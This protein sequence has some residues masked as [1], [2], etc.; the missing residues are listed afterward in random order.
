[1]GKIKNLLKDELNLTLRAESLYSDTL[2]SVLSYDYKNKSDSFLKDFSIVLRQRAMSG[3]PLNSLLPEAFALA[4]EASFRVLKLRPH[5]TQILA[6]IVLHN[7]QIAQMQTGEGKTLAAVLPAYLNGLE[8]KGVHILTFNDYLAKRD[9]EWMGPVFKFLGLSVG[10]ISGGMV[11]AERKMAYD[12]SVTYSSAKEVGFDYL[13]DFLCLKAELLVQRPFNFTI[14]DEADSIMIDEARIP[15]I[16]SG[17][18]TETEEYALKANKIVNNFKPGVHYEADQYDNNYYFTDEGINEAEK[19]LKIGNIYDEA[20]LP[21]LVALNGALTAYTLLQRDRNYLVRNNSIE[22]IDEFT[23]RV[24][25]QRLYPDNIQ[26]AVEI[27]EGIESNSRGSIM[28]RIALQHFLSLYQKLA[29]MTGTA[30]SAGYEFKSLYKM[31]V[32]EV[33]PYKPCQR[34]DQPDRVFMTKSQ[35]EKAIIEEVVSLNSKGQ[36]ILIGTVDIEES[37]QLSSM[38]KERGIRCSVLNAKNDEQEA[39]IIAEAGMPYAVTVSTNMAGRGVDIRLGGSDEREKDPVMAL[40]GLYVLGTN[41]HESVRID[42]QL[43]GRSG[44]QGEPGESRFFISLEDE[45]IKKY[46]SENVL[47]SRASM[48]NFSEEIFSEKIGKEI[49]SLQRRIEGY[50]SD[51]RRQMLSFS[52][53]IEKQRRVLHHLRNELLLGHISGSCSGLDKEFFR[54]VMLITIN[55]LWM[56][57]LEELES[58]REGIHLVA[59]GKKNPKDEFNSYAITAFN[60]LEKRL[61]SESLVNYKNWLGQKEEI[62]KLNQ[63]GPTSTFTYLLEEKLDGIDQ[64][65]QMVKVVSKLISIPFSTIKKLFSRAEKNRG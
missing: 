60:R 64:F 63:F 44:R 25:N 47:K 4:T 45:I 51:I 40:G 54:K 37:E 42:D 24:A 22:I 20:N 65:A 53:I 16:I 9:A 55:R 7:G 14:V 43:R 46:D 19:Q 17:K 57:Y 8:G 27:K 12:C 18:L 41:R 23:G 3:E 2:K 50:H 58:V 26:T 62:E 61:Q 33:S 38:L 1:M 48:G 34:K 56:D 29:G 30:K 49:I 15:L 36:P 28:G 52:S 21:Y 59:L 13:R 11:Q 35:K 10:Y 6:G 31:P 5:H 32:V 39:R